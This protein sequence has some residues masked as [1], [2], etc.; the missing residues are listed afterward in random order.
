MKRILT[1]TAQVISCSL[2][3]QSTGG[4]YI[5]TQTYLDQSGTNKLQSRVYDNGLG[6]IV[7]ESQIRAT[8][9]GNDLITLH[10]FD[11]YRRPVKTWLP[12]ISNANGSFVSGSTLQNLAR[13]QYDD[14]YPYQEQ[15]YNDTYYYTNI[16]YSYQP[17]AQY[18]AANKHKTSFMNAGSLLR[19][20]GDWYIDHTEFCNDGHFCL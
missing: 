3:A 17:G 11:V 5:T 10:E 15:T 13:Q 1:I 12:V 2:Y 19:I 16:Q 8:S 9:S 18:R 14:Q 6:D 20:S 4:S 7:E